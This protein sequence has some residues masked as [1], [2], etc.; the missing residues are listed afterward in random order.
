M[1]MSVEFGF[2]YIFYI[3][4]RWVLMSTRSFQKMSGDHELLKMD[5]KVE[6]VDSFLIRQHEKRLKFISRSLKYVGARLYVADPSNTDLHYATAEDLKD[7]RE[8]ELNATASMAL[9]RYRFS[10]LTTRKPLVILKLFHVP[11]QFV[12]PPGFWKSVNKLLLIVISSSFYDF[13]H[14]FVFDQY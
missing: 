11:A 5:G 4:K 13:H 9:E 3:D 12:P 8:I 7:L 2:L 14:M 1:T 6:R 10:F